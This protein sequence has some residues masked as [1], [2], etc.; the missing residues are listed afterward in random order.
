MTKIFRG[1][2]KA[3]I[4]RNYESKLQEVTV[5]PNV[6]KKGCRNKEEVLVNAFH[7]KHYIFCVAKTQA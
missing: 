4:I 7:G 6:V 5:G 2:L 1:F 3:S